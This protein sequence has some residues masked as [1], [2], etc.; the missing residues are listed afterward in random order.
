MTFF[1]GDDA[2]FFALQND[3]DLCVGDF[4]SFKTFVHVQQVGKQI[5]A[6]IGGGN[7]FVFEYAATD[8]NFAG[9]TIGAVRHNVNGSVSAEALF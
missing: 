6:F 2:M 5:V 9:G 1:V 3:F 7:L 4:I 8:I